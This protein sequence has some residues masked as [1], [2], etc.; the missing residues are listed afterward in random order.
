MFTARR[1][2]D[3]PDSGKW[4]AVNVAAGET[5]RIGYCARGCVGHTS[6]EEALAHYLS[7][8]LDREVDLWLERRSAQLACEIC[9]EPTTL[10]ARL[11]RESKLSVLCR[12]HQSTAS[13][14]TLFLRRV[15]APQ[16]AS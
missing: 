11:G 1:C 15:T 5:R 14:R 13:L 3:G 16:T 12:Q 8:Q 4:Y 10:R 6:S 2:E 7:Y 9:N